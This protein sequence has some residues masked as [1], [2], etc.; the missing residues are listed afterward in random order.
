MEVRII[1]VGNSK[2]LRLSKT[3]L[4]RYDIK[5]K[6]Q[7][8]MKDDHIRLVP[9]PEPRKGWAEQFQKMRKLGDDN[10]LMNDV[11]EDEVFE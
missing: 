1:Q 4:E 5:D 7:L 10:L 8:I 3:I 2:G 6:V 11:F 9:I